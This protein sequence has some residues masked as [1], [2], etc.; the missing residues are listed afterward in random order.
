LLTRYISPASTHCP[1]SPPESF[2]PLISTITNRRPKSRKCYLSSTPLEIMHCCSAARLYFIAI[3]TGF[4]ALLEFLTGF[5]RSTA[6][7]PP[8]KMGKKARLRVN[9]E[10][11]GLRSGRRQTPNS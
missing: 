1:F 6:R 5:T 10:P 2:L 11:L 3:P 9:L 8:F 7:S 4:I